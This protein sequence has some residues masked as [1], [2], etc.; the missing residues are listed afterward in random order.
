MIEAFAGPVSVSDALLARRVT[1]HVGEVGE[2]VDVFH[3][4]AACG[5]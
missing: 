1:R 5:A 3:G 2:I 4:V